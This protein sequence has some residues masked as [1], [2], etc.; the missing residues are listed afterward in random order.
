MNY[1]ILIL[2]ILILIF[3]ILNLMA[4][5][6]F[7]KYEDFAIMVESLCSNSHKSYTL[8]IETYR[9]LIYR[10]LYKIDNNE[11]D[12][13]MILFKNTFYIVIFLYSIIVFSFIKNTLIIKLDVLII[14][15]FIIVFYITYISMGF[16]IINKYN[17]IQDIKNDEKSELYKYAKIYKLLNVFMYMNNFQENKLKYSNSNLQLKKMNETL[18]TNISTFQNTANPSDI[19]GELY[20]GYK[21]LDYVKYLS[22]DR[23]NSRYYFKDYFNPELMYINIT[24]YDLFDR[25]KENIINYEVIQTDEEFIDY[26]CE[27]KVLTYDEINNIK[28]DNNDKEYIETTILNNV[29]GKEGN[30]VDYKRQYVKKIVFDNSNGTKTEEYVI[31]DCIDDELDE[32]E[33]K[34]EDSN[35][36]KY[37]VKKKTIEVAKISLKKLLEI[38]KFIGENPDIYT[39]VYSKLKR[40]SSNPDSKSINFSEDEIKVLLYL[41]VYIDIIY[42]LNKADLKDDLPDVLPDILPDS[43]IK[44]HF[45]T[46]YYFDNNKNILF[47]DNEN[48]FKD[49]KKYINDISSYYIYYLIYVVI[50]VF[51][52]LHYIYISLNNIYYTY[53]LLFIVTIYVAILAIIGYNSLL[54]R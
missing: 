10:F 3:M 15:V 19:V 29:E 4:I 21:N 30:D 22:F 12:N 31:N 24:Y 34:R 38:E 37:K 50:I 43:F 1:I 32:G 2:L 27:P 11:Y 5:L 18:Y 48:V 42:T 26:K 47:D 7:K 35:G 39:D 52:L 13:S 8:E 54:F 36:K 49:V 14:Y 46:F 9:H 17:N 51:L 33:S 44:K 20:R 28:K 40:F 45:L 53:L 41:T 23:L 6:N 16:T 25:I